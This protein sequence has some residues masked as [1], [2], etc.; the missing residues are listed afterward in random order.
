M[1]PRVMTAAPHPAGSGRRGARSA[2]R[3]SAQGAVLASAAAL[4][5]AAGLGCR[6]SDDTRVDG[7]LEPL[8]PEL[9][10]AGSLTVPL[11]T[12]DA[13]PYRLRR[14]VFDVERSGASVL[15]L[16]SEA[17]PDADALTAELDPGQ[18]QMRLNDGWSLE[19]L[20]A[21]GA[22][23]VRAAL[24][25]TNPVGFGVRDG[26]VTTVAFTFTTSGGVVTF[27]AGAV[28][29]RLGV[30][31]PSAL[32]SC[33]VLNQAG[34]AEGQHCL[35]GNADGKT[36]C[37]TPGQLPVGA[38]CS[39]EQCVFGAQCLGL[40][41]AAPELTTCS[42]LCNPLSP[43]FGCD[44]RGLGAGD[45][46]GVCG[47]PP[48]GTCDLLDSASCPDGLTCQYPGGSFGT[49]GTPGNAG[50]GESCFGEECTAGLDCF[51]DDPSLGFTGTCY[52]FCD[53]QAPDCEFCFE[54]DTGS[55]GRCFL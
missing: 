28:S 21:E 49:C 40:N 42:A 41:V 36:F 29:V 34:C 47:P 48:P 39:S 5:V 32:G 9:S 44:C 19:Q 35:L 50:E 37:A 55:V 10:A 1:K 6:A 22:S 20:D 7:S 4:L 51:G 15:S 45:D 46:V 26:R 43:P 27:G 13:A 30:M 3:R 8:A 23:P 53:V 12:P 24:I 52:R 38:P 2:H 11:I 17:D 33:D 54:V 14:A 31:D 16:D 25:S 18:Y